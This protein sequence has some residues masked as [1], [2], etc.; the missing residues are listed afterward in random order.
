MPQNESP[1]FHQRIAKGAGKGPKV[2]DEGRAEEDVTGEVHLVIEDILGSC[3]P[4]FLQARNKTRAE[5]TGG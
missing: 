2:G 3:C 4:T 1:A 5:A